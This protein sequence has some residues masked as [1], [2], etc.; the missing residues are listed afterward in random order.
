[1]V[2]AI[3]TD[4]SATDLV[5]LGWL[6]GKLTTAPDDREVI[7]GEGTTIGGIYYYLLDPAKAEPQVRRF[8]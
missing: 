4:L 7:A 8:S 3:S 6:Q 2:R 5:K 1:M